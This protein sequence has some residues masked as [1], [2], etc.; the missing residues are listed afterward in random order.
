MQEI[1]NQNFFV[2]NQNYFVNALNLVKNE[3]VNKISMLKT[4]HLCNDKNIFFSY[5]FLHLRKES[6]KTNFK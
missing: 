1:K 5:L 3:F 4:T 6:N 2:K